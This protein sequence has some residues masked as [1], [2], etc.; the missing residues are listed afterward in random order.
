MF[1]RFPALPIHCKKNPLNLRQNLLAAA[2][3]LET[4]LQMQKEVQSVK[5]DVTKKQIKRLQICA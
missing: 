1:K 3:S 4:N 5:S 2:C